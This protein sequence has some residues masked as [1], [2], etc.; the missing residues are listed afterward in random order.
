MDLFMLIF[1]SND[2]H[3]AVNTEAFIGLYDNT[4]ITTTVFITE[5]SKLLTIKLLTFIPVTVLASVTSNV[6]L[7]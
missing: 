2:Q 6:C 4:Y 3:F 1:Q 7:G 5:T